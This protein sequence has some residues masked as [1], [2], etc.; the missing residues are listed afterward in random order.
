MEKTPKNESI[1]GISGILPGVL[2]SAF[3]SGLAVL[4][5]QGEDQQRLIEEPFEDLLRSADEHPGIGGVGLHVA[6]HLGGI[7]A[8]NRGHGAG[9]ADIDRNGKQ[10]EQREQREANLP[11]HIV[12]AA[13]A[14]DVKA[15]ADRKTDCREDT[16]QDV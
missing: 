2:L 9:T 1:L 16:D 7:H 8:Q 14:R 11:R 10:T 5:E 3:V 6:Q 12:L 15:K 13:K 4:A